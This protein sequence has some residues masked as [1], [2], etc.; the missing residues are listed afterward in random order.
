MDKCASIKRFGRMQG[1]YKGMRRIITNTRVYISSLFTLHTWR[2]S[3][4]LA[5]FHT[6]T[7][8]IYTDR[9]LSIAITC[10][11]GWLKHSH[12]GIFGWLLY[13]H[14]SWVRYSG[15][16]TQDLDIFGRIFVRQTIIILILHAMFYVI[17]FVFYN[18]CM[19][20]EILL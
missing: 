19:K 18:I 11:K 10:N 3:T 17:C 7:R 13:S 4:A 1:Y 2:G 20:P 8:S 6:L 12:T 9:F 5:T 15:T 16:C 14:V